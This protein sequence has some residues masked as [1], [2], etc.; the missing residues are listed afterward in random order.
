M[1]PCSTGREN[2]SFAPVLSQQSLRECA[3][4]S[5]PRHCCQH[6]GILDFS[7]CLPLL[8][9]RAPVVSL[10]RRA[11]RHAPHGTQWDSRRSLHASRAGQRCSHQALLLS[12]L[13]RVHALKGRAGGHPEG[14]SHC[15]ICLRIC[16]QR[17]QGGQEGTGAGERGDR[18]S[19]PGVAVQ[20]ARYCAGGEEDQGE[21]A[22]LEE[23]DRGG[24]G[25]GAQG[26]GGGGGGGPREA[27]GHPGPG[28]GHFPHR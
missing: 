27:P 4:S 18:E 20:A 7:A 19:P 17:A 28:E 9:C 12:G 14:P 2:T 21:A 25:A 16:S 6:V 11:Q 26:E 10:N 15:S 22:R 8:P 3:L 24:G 13:L 5:Q 1:R 23:R